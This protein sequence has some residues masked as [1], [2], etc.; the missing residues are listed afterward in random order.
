MPKH[1][2]QLSVDLQVLLIENLKNRVQQ[3]T[4]RRVGGLL[5]NL[6]TGLPAIMLGSQRGQPVDIH[7]I[8]GVALVRAA[9]HK[10]ELLRRHTDSLENCGDNFLVVFDAVLN[11]FQGRLHRI[12]E[13][14]HIG[15]EDNDFTSRGEQL[16]NL[17]RGDEVSGVRLASGSST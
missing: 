4:Q 10:L 15:K 8:V 3:T 13:G 14:V 7:N 6:G 16:G 17:E 12:Q 1:T 11:Q 5:N 9:E 2:A